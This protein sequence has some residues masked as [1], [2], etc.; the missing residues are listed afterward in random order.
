MAEA[1]TVTA[2]FERIKKKMGSVTANKDD[3]RLIP[4]L[5]QISFIC[6]AEITEAEQRLA[7]KAVQ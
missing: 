2:A 3:K 4:V 5:R 7:A 1:K 6:Q